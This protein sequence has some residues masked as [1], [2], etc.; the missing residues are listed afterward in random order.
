MGCDASLYIGGDI[1]L[2]CLWWLDN[3]SVRWEDV[4]VLNLR[5]NDFITNAINIIEVKIVISFLIVTIFIIWY[6]LFSYARFRKMILID[7]AFFF[8]D[9]MIQSIVRS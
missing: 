3:I 9:L 1:L 8:T 2:I 5:W 6:N 4:I 7:D